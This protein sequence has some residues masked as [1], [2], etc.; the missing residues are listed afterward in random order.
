LVTLGFDPTFSNASTIDDTTVPTLTGFIVNTPIVDTTSSSAEV[1]VTLNITDDLSGVDRAKIRLVSPSGSLQIAGCSMTGGT[2]LNAVFECSTNIPQLS[3]L[4]IWSFTLV[5]IQDVVGNLDLLDTADLVT[6]GFDPTFLNTSTA[7]DTT[8]PVLANFVVNTPVVDT[9][10]G[11]AE[12][13]VT[14]NVTD[15][16]S[17]VDRAVIR[18]VN[19]SGMLRIANCS[20]VG[21]T[22]LDTDFECSTD[23]PQFSELGIWSFTLVEIQDVVGNLDLLDTADLVTLGFDPTFINAPLPSNDTDGDGIP[24]DIDNCP[25]SDLS[26]TVVVDACDSGVTNILL[27]D[28]CT[29]S[30]EIAECAD[31]ATKHGKFVGCASKLLR[32]LKKKSVGIITNDEADAIKTCVA[33]ADIP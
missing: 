30:D 22:T 8:P 23:I 32:S 25:N 12:V 27:A 28:G 18:L 1:R 14:L 33:E 29:I 15:D 5:E 16:L 10:S 4:G 24:D 21:G 11:P 7:D 9:T 19:P 26:S 31:G 2:A 20:I 13:R 6:L 3:E 17:G